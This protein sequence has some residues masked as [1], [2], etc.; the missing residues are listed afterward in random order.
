[1]PEHDYYLPVIVTVD[2]DSSTDPDLLL[3]EWQSL[4]IPVARRLELPPPPDASIITDE[5]LVQLDAATIATAMHPLVCNA[6]A[7]LSSEEPAPVAEKEDLETTAQLKGILSYVLR[8]RS[9]VR[10]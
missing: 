10:F 6:S 8:V 4:N 3:G 9:S 5:Q 1:M 7:C 2:Q